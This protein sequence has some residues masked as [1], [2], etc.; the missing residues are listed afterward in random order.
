[1]RKLFF[2][3]VVM[4]AFSLTSFGGTNKVSDTIVK[5]AT[6][7]AIDVNQDGGCV[8]MGCVYVDT[9]YTPEGFPRHT[10]TFGTITICDEVME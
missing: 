10:Y 5:A 7:A 9:Y 8:T 2:C 6:S 4:I 1:M 3:A